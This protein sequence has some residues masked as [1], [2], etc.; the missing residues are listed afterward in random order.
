VVW[1][2][3]MKKLCLGIA[4]IL[5]LVATPILA[6]D[7]PVKAPAPVVSPEYDWSGLYVGASVG[8]MRGSYDWRYTNPSPLFVGFPPVPVCCSFKSASVTD[9]VIGG[10]IGAQ[11]QWNH[12]VIGV[13]FAAS[14][15][16]RGHKAKGACV[17][18]LEP[19]NCEV[20]SAAIETLGGRL[21][22]AW[23]NWLIYG[24][25][26]GARSSVAS[27]L[28]TGNNPPENITYDFTAL[29]YK[30]WY[31]GAGVEYVLMKGGV[32]D[33]I[34]GLEYQHVDLGTHTHLSSLDFPAFSAC[35]PG[36]N[37]R[38]IS[39]KDSLV[40]FRL[41]VKLNPFASPRP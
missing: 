27:D 30:G 19:V 22:Y 10:H 11:W 12:I 26:G 39:A 33:L 24:A 32:F 6:A 20:Q 8:W 17:S 5:A 4:A 29:T 41:S 36:N 23:S 13:E 37:C 31:A 35:P 21:G 25:G 15:P 28:Y 9:G 1:G 14:E 16:W 7:M 2:M 38:A 18:F 34:G 40:R 3:T